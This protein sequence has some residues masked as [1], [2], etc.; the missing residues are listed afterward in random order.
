M[1][2]DDKRNCCLLEIQETEAKYYRTLEDIEKVGVGLGAVLGPPVP[3]GGAVPRQ[4]H[5]AAVTGA[6]ASW[7]SRLCRQ[8]PLGLCSPHRPVP[9]S[10]VTLV[11]DP[12]SHR[13]ALD[14]PEL[15]S[16]ALSG[17]NWVSLQLLF[18]IAL[19]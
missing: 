2:E 8:A 1:S 4:G 3:W 11:P 9:S 14:H 19:G 10:T 7:P 12:T 5:R 17:L 15:V 18:P 16:A 13:S 6:E